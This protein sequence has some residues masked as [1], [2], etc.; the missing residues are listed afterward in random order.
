MKKLTRSK[1]NK[2]VSGVL[3]GLGSYFDVDPV[4]F[5]LLFALL[6]V[7]TGVF[8]GILIYIVAILIIPLETE[9]T[10]SKPVDGTEAHD[11]PEV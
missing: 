4:I 8:P 6:L 3:G 10:P 1:S 11:S 5:R 2:M 9:F 7:A